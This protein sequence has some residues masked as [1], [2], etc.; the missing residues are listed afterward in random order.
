MSRRLLQITNL[1]LAILTIGLAGASLVFG[2]HNPIYDFKEVIENPALDSNLRFMGGM[3]L[4]LG[5]ALLWIT[6]AIEKYSLVFRIIW[7][8]ALLG[9]VGRLISIYFVGNPPLPMVIFTVI[10]V[11]LVPLLIYWQQRVSLSSVDS[12]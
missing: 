2:V 1:I 10:E 11:P 12:R 3:G 9:G 8:S 6:P 5:L 4:G 7:I